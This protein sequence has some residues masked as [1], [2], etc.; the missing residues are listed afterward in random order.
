MKI[1]S[2]KTSREYKSGTGWSYYI[3]YHTIFEDSEIV[4]TDTLELM[5]RSSY[6][7]SMFINTIEIPNREDYT[8]V[9]KILINSQVT[10]KYDTNKDKVKTIIKYRGKENK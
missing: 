9:I 7:D 8:E 6:A 1:L 2:L 4:F 5:N 10:D 3:E